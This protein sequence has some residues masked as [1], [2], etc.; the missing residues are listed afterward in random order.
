MKPRSV[1]VRLECDLRR[2]PIDAKE[3]F[4]VS[5]LDGKIT[6]E[7]A[8][9]LMGVSVDEV[10]RLA[11]R[12]S[13][14]GAVSE[15]LERRSSR[16]RAP[17]KRVDPR[18]EIE[19]VR[20]P[21]NERQITQVRPTRR[22]SMRPVEE[23]R[24]LPAKESSRPRRLSNRPRKSLVT[25][26]LAGEKSAGGTVPKPVI[27]EKAPEPASAQVTSVEPIDV[28]AQTGKFRRLKEAAQALAGAT[29]SEAVLQAADDALRAGDIV[30]AANNYRLALTMHDDPMIRRKLDAIDAQARDVRYEK[31]I[32]RA[33][34]AERAERWDEAAE[35]YQRANE[36]RR[37][38]ACAERAAYALR[39]SKGDLRLAATL[40]EQAIEHDGKNVEYRVTLGEVYLAAGG[41][42]RAKAESDAALALSAN[43]PRA[44]ALAAAIRRRS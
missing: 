40:G 14:L 9:E 21:K 25:A 5:Q 37:E 44:K 19:S 36:A 27:V 8:S 3:A 1:L 39:M 4:L 17:V 26:A 10:I 35:H 20:P 13:S 2:L 31:H 11:G 30:G 12:L 42:E 23:S 34:G 16:P 24:E 7:E 33:R 22:K 18:A 15:P 41:V 29:R 28:V 32:V 6:L 43:H 38:A